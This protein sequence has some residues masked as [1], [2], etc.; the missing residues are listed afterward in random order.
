MAPKRCPLSGLCFVGGSLM[1]C[2]YDSRL[3]EPWPRLVAK[4]EGLLGGV[5]LPPCATSGELRRSLTARRQTRALF[6]LAHI[7]GRKSDRHPIML[8][9]PVKRS[10]PAKNG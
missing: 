10:S 1:N 6:A 9:V 3:L 5:M 4:P 8:V 2:D 7:Y